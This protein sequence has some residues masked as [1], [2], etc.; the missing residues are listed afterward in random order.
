MAPFAETEI[1]A[2]AVV[3]AHFRALESNRPDALFR[4]E[5]AERF[6][7]A[8]GLPVSSIRLSD[9]T[10][11]RLYES[12]A[13]R[14]RWLDSAVEEGISA[15]C[16]QVVLLAAGLDSRAFR[17]NV[18]EGTRF[19][20]LDLPKLLSF[21]RTVL[22]ESGIECRNDRVEV[23]VDLT[24][25]SW[26]SRLVGAGFDPEKMT[27]WLAEGL[28]MY[29]DSARTDQLIATVTSLSAPGSRL[30][31]SQFGPGSVTEAQTREIAQR[32]ASNGYGFQSWIADPNS[33]LAQ[34]GW[35]VHATTI[36]AHGAELGRVLPYTETSGQ[37]IAWLAKAE[38]PTV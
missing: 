29:F 14:T 33:W 10:S 37:E 8:S 21:K 20:E 25:E 17:M 5:F 16:A 12:V 38:L 28:L 24:H 27:M 7:T 31:F 11:Q 30:A 19:F 1:S 2:T 6:V 13:V 3:I 23:S 4:D 32:T 36:K 26:P 34:W 18:A 35:A 22:D 15:G 9:M